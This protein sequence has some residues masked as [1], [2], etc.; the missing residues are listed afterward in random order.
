MTRFISINY[1]AF[2]Q[3]LLHTGHEMCYSVRG[4]RPGLPGRQGQPGGEGGHSGGQQGGPRQ[5]QEG[6]GEP[7]PGNNK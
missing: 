1:C 4:H 3:L 7:G 5:D 2:L 6:P